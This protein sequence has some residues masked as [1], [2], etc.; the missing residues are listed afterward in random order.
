MATYKIKRFSSDTENDESQKKRSPQDP[1]EGLNKDL[2]KTGIVTGATIYG[3][4]KGKKDLNHYL[5]RKSDD[6]EY[7]YDKKEN[8]EL[9]K[10]L[11]RIAKK[12]KTAVI[13]SNIGEYSSLI[14]ENERKEILDELKRSKKFRKE[15]KEGKKVVS[16][17]INEF[18]KTRK[19]NVIK[20]LKKHNKNSD[21]STKEYINELK[22]RLNSIDS[23]HTP[24]NDAATLAHELGHSKCYKDR[25]SGFGKKIHKLSHITNDMK[26]TMIISSGIASG[27][28]SYADK[29]EG[30]KES[31]ISKYAPVIS[32]VAMNAPNLLSEAY[33]SYDG[34][35]RLKNLGASDK[36]LKNYKKD[37]GYCL[38]T[39][40]TGVL[41]DTGKGYVARQSGKLLGRGLHALEK[42]SRNKNKKKEKE[43]NKDNEKDI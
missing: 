21:K 11:K 30:K 28:N 14:K 20:D 38:G 36:F 27:L 9:F 32:S 22:N 33:A 23:I 3:V 16:D 25:S 42:Y 41:T 13:S 2:I 15:V 43:E 37:L 7:K 39:Y 40:A 29:I 1:K 19:A 26:N 18:G 4:K 8:K 5:S 17:Y 35:K 31:K 34:Y 6:I 24:N 10:K 12:Q